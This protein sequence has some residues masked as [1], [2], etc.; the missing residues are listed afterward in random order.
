MVRMMKT[1][2][3]P[4]LLAILP[5]MLLADLL[6]AAG[7]VKHIEILA[8]KKMKIASSSGQNNT[9]TCTH[10]HIHTVYTYTYTYL[11]IIVIKKREQICFFR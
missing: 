3:V 2:A 11:K 6:C 8:I 1:F 9:Y 4:L 5:P 7:S 10:T